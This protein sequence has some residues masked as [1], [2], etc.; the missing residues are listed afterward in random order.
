[1]ELAPEAISAEKEK[2][3]AL[4]GSFK[5]KT[6]KIAMEALRKT[7]DSVPENSGE[8]FPP[9][10]VMKATLNEN[11]FP[12]Q[13]KASLQRDYGVAKP[14]YAA[15]HLLDYLAHLFQQHSKKDMATWCGAARDTLTAQVDEALRNRGGPST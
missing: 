12:E 9:P 10:A 11:F 14:E 1:M 2:I 7:M 5:S 4:F 8:Y 15:Y 6:I 13:S 3:M